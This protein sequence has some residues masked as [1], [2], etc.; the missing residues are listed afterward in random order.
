MLSRTIFPST[1][2]PYN[3]PKLF[4]HNIIYIYAS[5][6]PIGIFR[7]VW[8]PKK[9][10]PGTHQICTETIGKMLLEVNLWG[11]FLGWQTIRKITSCQWIQFWPAP[12]TV[13]E[14]HAFQGKPNTQN[15]LSSQVIGTLMAMLFSLP[16]D[17]GRKVTHV[18]TFAGCASVT[19]G[20]IQAGTTNN[21]PISLAPQ[22]LTPTTN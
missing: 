17:W 21:F 7:L 13:L 15:L 19:R 4:M 2:I 16:L 20:E 1:I 6:L 3:H 11:A 9:K 10:P 5:V 12:F 18:E 8:H 14:P 22:N